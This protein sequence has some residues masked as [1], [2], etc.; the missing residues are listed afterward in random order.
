MIGVHEQFGTVA[1][2]GLEH[3]IEVRDDVSVGVENG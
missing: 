1:L 3:G 2:T